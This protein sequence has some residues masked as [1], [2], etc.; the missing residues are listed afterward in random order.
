M[1]DIQTER[2]L[3][4]FADALFE[5]CDNDC[6]KKVQAYV[7]IENI[8]RT[9]NEEIFEQIGFFRGRPCPSDCARKRRHA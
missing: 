1:I 9:N 2:V 6:P 3:M 8:R 7:I 4:A 5:D